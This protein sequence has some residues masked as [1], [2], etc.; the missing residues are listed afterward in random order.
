MKNSIQSVSKNKEI[1]TYVEKNTEVDNNTGEVLKEHE[2]QV[3]KV[4][5]RDNF[6]KLFVD[7]LAFIGSDLTNAERQVLVAFLGKINYQNIVYIHSELRADMAIQYNISKATISIGI[8]G[9]KEKKIILPLTATLQERFGIYSKNAFLINPDIAGKGSF[10][11]LQKLR[12]EI[13]IEYDFETLEIKKA[14]TT[15]SQ[16]NGFNDVVKNIDNH[17]VKEVKQLISDDKKRKS[18]EVV[19]AEKQT[20]DNND[21]ENNKTQAFDKEE[22]QL[23]LELKREENKERELRIQEMEI[24]LKLRKTNTQKGLFDDLETNVLDEDL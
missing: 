9:L 22:L 3:T 17:E 12:Q 10:N 2:I 15:K 16:Y 8:K 11:E 6:I 4:K 19:L 21:K 14:Y 20:I 18:T 1:V 13:Q 5:H 7:N 24:R 23:Q